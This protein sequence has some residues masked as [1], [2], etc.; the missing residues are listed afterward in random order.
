MRD[1]MRP[2]VDPMSAAQR[3]INQPGG[4]RGF[5]RRDQSSALHPLTGLA[6]LGL[7]WLLFGGE[8]LSG[9]LLEPL[10]SPLGALAGFISTFLIERRYAGRSF[11]RS[12]LAALF[13]A[14][15]VGVPWPVSGTLIGLA[16]LMLSGLRGR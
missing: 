16:V 15:V 14:A 6:I 11:G 12:V 9:F 13:A 5:L 3:V 1:G 7:D 2:D 4:V 8:L 10:L